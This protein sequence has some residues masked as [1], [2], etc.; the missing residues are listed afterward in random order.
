MRR[1][2][3][4]AYFSDQDGGLR[5]IRHGWL[6]KFA[7]LGNTE[8]IGLILASIK[9]GDVCAMF[10]ISFAERRRCRPSCAPHKQACTHQMAARRRQGAVNYFLFCAKCPGWT[11]V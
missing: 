4:E 9:T 8:E 3:M 6:R 1:K 10:Y 11:G 7:S 5:K 2:K